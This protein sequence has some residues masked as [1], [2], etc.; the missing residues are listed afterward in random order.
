LPITRANIDTNMVQ[1][2]KLISSS[3]KLKYKYESD[4]KGNEYDYGSPKH[5]Q[6]YYYLS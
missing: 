6:L 3:A 1:K 2:E 5:I 4:T